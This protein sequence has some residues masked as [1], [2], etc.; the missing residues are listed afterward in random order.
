LIAVLGS[1]LPVPLR[2]IGVF[3]RGVVVVPLMRLVRPTMRLLGFPMLVGGAP[4]M[5]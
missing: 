3:T 2:L 5:L 4:V 1:F